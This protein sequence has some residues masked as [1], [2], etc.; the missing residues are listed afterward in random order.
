MPTDDDA[1]DS[2][3][4]NEPNYA[5][6]QTFLKAPVVEPTE[7]TS[8][9]DVGVIGLPFDGAVSNQ[10]GARYGP[11]A[12]RRASTY[13]GSYG[14]PS[15]TV[16]TG[17]EIDFDR[18]ELRDCGDGLVYPNDV[19]KTRE[20]V[21]E[22]IGHLADTVF[23]VILG[24][25]HYLTYPSYLGVAETLDED[26]GLIHLDAHSDTHGRWDLYGDHWHGSPMNLIADTEYGGYEN[27]AMVGIRSRED[28]A[29]PE[30][31]ADG[32]LY[33]D[34]ARDVRDDG[35]EACIDRAIDHATDGVETVY[36]TV[37]IDVID[38]AFA[39][40]T[41]TPEPGGLTSWDLLAAMDR[42]GEVEA[43]AAMDLVEVAP[44][45][46]PT[47]A[48]QKLAAY[49]ITRFLEAKFMG[50]SANTAAD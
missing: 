46:D 11:E 9:I 3:K 30:L 25:D 21:Q 40:G 2:Q 42:L 28:P 44:R 49:A 7:L 18:V 10:P 48:T 17:R 41:G 13:Y 22:T 12:I 14:G 32:G 20:S 47:R 15:L 50:P 29:F 34:Y 45:I 31:I 37:D 33:V 35:I 19:G 8:D 23:P 27:H 39:P 38:P 36:L 43:I 16:E 4:P 1:V 5:G 6:I 24:G 26:V